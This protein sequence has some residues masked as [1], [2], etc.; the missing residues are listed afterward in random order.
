MAS[1]KPSNRL[2]CIACLI[3]LTA[4]LSSQARSTTTVTLEKTGNTQAEKAARTP[5]PPAD[6][7]AE[8][9]Y[10]LGMQY[11]Y[12]K[13]VSAD[14]SK[15]IE[16]LTLSANNNNPDAQYEIYRIKR[17]EQGLFFKDRQAEKWLA[18]AAE[19][20]HVNAM[21]VMGINSMV[22]LEDKN[23][24]KNAFYWFRRAALGGHPQAQNAIGTLY[25]YGT[26]VEKNMAEA[27]QWYEKS[28]ARQNGM[29]L[30][31]L[32]RL[33]ATG[34][35]VS[36]NPDKAFEL[37]QKALDL[38]DPYAQ[39]VFAEYYRRGIG[40]EKNETK[41]FELYE[42]SAQQLFA[43]AAL[44]LALIHE[45]GL[46]G[47]NASPEKAKLW[48][49]IYK[50]TIQFLPEDL[51]E[52]LLKQKKND[53]F[54]IPEKKGYSTT[55]SVISSFFSPGWI[56]FW[57]IILFTGFSI[58]RRNKIK[59][60]LDAYENG[61][62]QTAYNI[63]SKKYIL[64]NPDVQTTIG[65]MYLY[66]HV[67]EADY[68]KAMKY[69]ILA[70]SERYTAQFYIGLM[71]DDGLGVVRDEKKAAYWYRLAAENGSC[72]AQNNLGV[73]YY[74]G[75][76]VPQNHEKAC[77]CFQQSADWVCE[78]AKANLACLYHEGKGVPKDEIKA[79]TMTSEC[80]ETGNLAGRYNLALYWRHVNP[81]HSDEQKTLQMIKDCA[82]DG[83]RPAIE[84]LITVYE[85]GE[86]GEPVNETLARHWKDRLDQPQA[87]TEVKALIYQIGQE[88]T[89]NT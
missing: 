71:F 56:V 13:G 85:K 72:E 20:G 84:D 86:L 22:N 25:E 6:K 1:S 75:K 48:R 64:K 53:L 9:Q 57:L 65:Q 41:A 17:E 44:E 73:L 8:S 40:V 16:L 30:G 55:L 33:Y 46:L 14:R 49:E 78:T 21:N 34:T 59:Q 2:V 88:Q 11:Y 26:G 24:W 80:A 7:N 77:Q 45:S 31:N 54:P 89:Q 38:N 43:P 82:N 29:A 52:T 74:T 12:G 39:Y 27:V 68:G 62:Y 36:K 67:V 66:G 61:K 47:Q 3:L 32:G 10:R 50:N 60:G 81:T 23:R 87:L 35:G 5:I 83:Y 4:S 58:H 18:K 37:Y 79:F 15:G 69:F 19:N 42:K 70:A 76:G 28:A 51:S 63:L